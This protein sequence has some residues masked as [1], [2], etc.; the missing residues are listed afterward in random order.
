MFE[1]THEKTYGIGKATSTSQEVLQD[2]NDGVHW[3]DLGITL[4]GQKHERA[5]SEAVRNSGEA[6]DWP[7]RWIQ[8]RLRA[9]H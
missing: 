2:K 1:G 7:S 3:Y 8:E 9:A 4:A 6:P 5:A